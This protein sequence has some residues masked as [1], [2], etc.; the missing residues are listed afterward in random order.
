MFKQDLNDMMV[1]LAVVE[2]GSFTLA[3]DRLD[4]PKANVSRKVSRL[5]Q[6]LGVTLLERSTRSQHLTEA[7]SRYLAHCKRIHEE[8][9]LATS[10]VSELLNEYKGDIKLGASVTIGQQILKPS[11]PAFLQSYPELN[12]ELNLLNER[13]DLIEE[14][15]D[16][17]IRVGA[18]NDSRLIAKRL[19]TSTLQLYASPDYLNKHPA[20]E[21]PMIFKN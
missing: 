11:L 1:F 12:L 16:V 9:E 8:M 2:T 14:G 18:L 13:V 20:I 6:R 4:I 10:A 15:Y 19:G 17:L 7:G 21:S 5:E 3:A